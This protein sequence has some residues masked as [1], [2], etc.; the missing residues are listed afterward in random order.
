[1]QRQSSFS[2]HFAPTAKPNTLNTSIPQTHCTT[3]TT[4]HSVLTST[5]H[6]P[7]TP[8]TQQEFDDLLA[9]LDKFPSIDSETESIDQNSDGYDEV[10]ELGD[11]Y[12][13]DTC[14]TQAVNEKNIVLLAEENQRLKAQMYLLQNQGSLS[15][16]Y[17]QQDEQYVYDHS[18]VG[19]VDPIMSTYV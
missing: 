15:G 4:Q 5:E 3:Q 8:L 1:M 6:L 9:G 19:A 12:F 14:P 13:G 7:T 2:I 18:A 11:T 16:V 17:N 10:S